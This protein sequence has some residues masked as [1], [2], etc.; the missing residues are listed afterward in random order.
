MSLG[1]EPDPLFVA[2]A[3]DDVANRKIYSPE[4]KSAALAALM[5]NAGCIKQTASQLGIPPP[6]LRR[7]RNE[8]GGRSD[9]GT[10]AAVDH[11]AAQMRVVAE[12]MLG[13]LQSEDRLAK[14]C[15]RDLAISFGIVMDKLELLT[16]SRR[17]EDGALDGLM[18]E[19]Q[20]AREG[21]PLRQ[22]QGDVLQAQGR[23]D[24]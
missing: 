14:A 2:D 1:D 18:A 7:W 4:H 15:I 21:A 24:E 5:A 12:K 11:L 6:T 3:N 20:R 9:P 16:D 10:E 13:H 23:G 19:I 17:N 22:A 8:A